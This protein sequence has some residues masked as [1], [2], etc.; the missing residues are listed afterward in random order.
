MDRLKDKIVLITG[1]AGAV[2][3][4]VAEAV[5]GAG[6][7]AVT[8]DLAGPRASAHALDVT[9]EA[10]WL[11][12]IADDR[13]DP[14]SARWAGQ[15]RGPCG[16]RHHRGHRFRDL[17][18]DSRRQSRRHVSRLQA[19]AAAAQAPRRLDRQ[20]VVGGG[21]DRRA[22][23]RR[24]QRLQGRRAAAH[25]IGRA[26][27]RAARSAGALQFDPS[28][29]PRRADGGRDPRQTDYPR[30][31]ARPHA[32]ATFRSAGSAP[33]TRSPRCASICCPTNPASSPAPSSS[34]TAA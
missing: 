14:R 23:L 6:G 20:P 33:P 11:R 4:A 12:V 1:A 10:D 17:A 28:G 26:A 18:A 19:R 25:Q 29:L 8:S 7:I 31:R 9:S 30:C 3:Q 22:Q 16:A 27:R 15:R 5:N 32:R 21:P 13:Q 24:L 2:G 34:S